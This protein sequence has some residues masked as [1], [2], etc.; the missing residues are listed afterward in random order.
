MP[1]TRHAAFC[2]EHDPEGICQ[3]GDIEA[4]K[5]TIGLSR[6]DG[7]TSVWLHHPTVIPDELAGRLDPREALEMGRALIVQG[8]RGLTTADMRPRI[9]PRPVHTHPSEV[10]Q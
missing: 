1:D 9:V 5:W 8:M 10:G 6:C 3:A 4:G 7:E 2:A